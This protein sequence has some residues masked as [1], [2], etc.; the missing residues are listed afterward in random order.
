MCSLQ[1]LHVASDFGHLDLAI[2]EVL[3]L[4]PEDARE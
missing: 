4:C 1:D 3:I 2:A